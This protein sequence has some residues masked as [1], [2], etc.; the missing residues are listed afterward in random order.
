MA[1][2]KLRKQKSSKAE[3]VQEAQAK[4]CR[5]L[6]WIPFE[7]YMLN[8]FYCNV[9]STKHNRELDREDTHPLSSPSDFKSF[10]PKDFKE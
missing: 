3:E 1:K 8:D 4:C 2:S 6:R 7:E 5:C 9:C 10:C